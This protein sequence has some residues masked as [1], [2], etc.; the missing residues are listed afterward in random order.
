[1]LYE[2]K[3][4]KY[5]ITELVLTNNKNGQLQTQILVILILRNSAHYRSGTLKPTWLLVEQ[6]DSKS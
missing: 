2:P 5:F 3:F 4:I 1:M 6:S